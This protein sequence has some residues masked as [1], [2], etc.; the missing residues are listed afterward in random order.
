MELI[1]YAS[2]S[3]YY[4]DALLL[5]PP[6]DHGNYRWNAT[7]CHRYRHGIPGGHEAPR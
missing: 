3:F 6:T 7:E 4:R 2:C 1:S 5:D